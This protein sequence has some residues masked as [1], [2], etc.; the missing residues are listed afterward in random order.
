MPD[1]P[2]SN[3][4]QDLV[5]TLEH[6]QIFFTTIYKGAESVYKGQVVNYEDRSPGFVE[7]LFKLGDRTRQSVI[8][9][10]KVEQ[11]EDC[12]LLELLRADQQLLIQEG[13]G[14]VWIPKLELK[15][16]E[17]HQRLNSTLNTLCFLPLLTPKRIA[18]APTEP[19]LELSVG[20]RVRDQRYPG[21][22][23][24]E[25][26]ILRFEPHPNSHEDWLDIWV[27]L[28]WDNGKNQNLLACQLSTAIKDPP[29]QDAVLPELKNLEAERDRLLKLPIAPTGTWIETGKVPGRP[30]E[31]RQAYWRSKSAVFSGANGNKTKKKYIGV[32][33][34]PE[35]EAAR[36]TIENRIKKSQLERKIKAITRLKK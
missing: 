5:V 33:G 13:I 30:A 32:K 1:T 4:P 29:E 19:G 21:I 22:N 6:R 11:I 24:G 12:D 28:R 7:V 8:P 15:I 31:W 35:H 16:T 25:G 26:V 14:Q 27:S 34:G 9:L 23:Q 3:N 17:I 10:W 20:D 18:D 2:Q 36:G